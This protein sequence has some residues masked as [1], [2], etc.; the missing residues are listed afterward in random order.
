MKRILSLMLLTALLLSLTGA[1]LAEDLP[2]IV[3]AVP[4]DEPKDL[5]GGLQAIN[6]KLKTDGAGVQLELRYYPWDAWDQK[7]NIMLSTGE[8]FDV[9]Q[10]M[11]DRVS[12]SNYASRGALTDITPYMESSGQNILAV[13]PPIM[14]ASGQV[15]GV[16][17]AVPAYW[18]ES[19]LDPE[20]TIRKDILD[21]YNLPLPT[22][23][24]ELTAAFETV[25]AKWDG[26]QKPFIPLIGANSARFGL[27]S[28]EY[29]EWP[30]VIYDKLFFVGQDGKVRNYFETD[31]FRR[32]SANARLWYE[33]GL[34]NPDVLT[35]TSGVSVM[36]A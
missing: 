3:Y 31:V 18:V 11:N 22:S 24:E 10:V 8:K 7:I 34:I 28:M 30:Y 20:L 35:T 15:G 2:T 14:M 16:Q 21:K 17:Y 5:A 27:A 32:D 33:K 6:D 12:L 29:E 25:M 9:F 1:S 26:N 4:G 36:A 13:C 23:F 19:A